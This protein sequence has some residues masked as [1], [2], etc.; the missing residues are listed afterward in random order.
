MTP[1]FFEMASKSARFSGFT[2]AMKMSRYCS[3]PWA[4]AITASNVTTNTL[5]TALVLIEVFSSMVEFFGLGPCKSGT[6]YSRRDG[7]STTNEGDHHERGE[8]EIR[9]EHHKGNFRLEC[10]T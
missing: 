10:F 5:H 4:A 2:C 3:C 6:R 9:D 8:N 7:A 1:I